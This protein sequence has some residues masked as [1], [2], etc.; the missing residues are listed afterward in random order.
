MRLLMFILAGAWLAAIPSLA[1]ETAA[2]RFQIERAGDGFIRLNRSSGEVSFCAA[3]D[4][5]WMC[6]TITDGS[7]DAGANGD[8][9]GRLASIEQRLKAL[10]E[11]PVTTFPSDQDLDRA[12]D[13]FGRFLDRFKA[14]A[15]DLNEADKTG[16]Q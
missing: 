9:A 12:I 8:F 13:V 16:S 2:A 14:F 1:E 6:R 7:P 11:R 4:G 5:V 3:E 15:R 10:E